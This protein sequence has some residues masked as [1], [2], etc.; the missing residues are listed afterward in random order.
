MLHKMVENRVLNPTGNTWTATA[1]ATIQKYILSLAVDVRPDCQIADF[2]IL[3][4]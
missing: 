3:I 1:V 4:S 2:V